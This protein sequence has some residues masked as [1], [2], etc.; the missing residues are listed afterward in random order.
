MRV[1]TIHRQ[2]AG[3]IWLMRG[4]VSYGANWFGTGPIRKRAILRE[5]M[6]QTVRFGAPW[7]WD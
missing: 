7:L 3:S 6:R 5:K 2:W 1:E 4:R